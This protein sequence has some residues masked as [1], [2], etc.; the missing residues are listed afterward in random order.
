MQLHHLQGVDG[1][2]MCIHLKYTYI[3]IFEIEAMCGNARLVNELEM[4]WCFE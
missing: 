2:F 1:Y 4:S 3:Y